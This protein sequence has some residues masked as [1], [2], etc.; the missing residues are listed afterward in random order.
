M[1]PLSLFKGHLVYESLLVRPESADHPEWGQKFLD[2]KGG[3][4]KSFLN[5]FLTVLSQQPHWRQK[6]PEIITEACRCPATYSEII[7]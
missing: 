6:H 1:Q 7:V 4:N 5:L 2:G 3:N